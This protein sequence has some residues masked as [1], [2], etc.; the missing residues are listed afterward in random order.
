M[1]R[2]IIIEDNLYDGVGETRENLFFLKCMNKMK[3]G[4][5]KEGMRKLG[6]CSVISSVLVIS[7]LPSCVQPKT[8]LP[9]APSIKHSSPDV[10]SLQDYQSKKLH[11]EERS[12][13]FSN[14]LFNALFF[15]WLFGSSPDDDKYSS[16][17]DSGK[18]KRE[19]IRENSD[20]I[21]RDLETKK[22]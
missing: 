22:D 16:S 1:F 10:L 19:F 13:S 8:T 11:R 2:L 14:K 17:R 15:G 12:K 4:T 3:Q 7:I 20:T 9:S 18:R 5:V 21:V 6:T